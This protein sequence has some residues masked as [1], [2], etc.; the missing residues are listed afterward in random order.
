MK[1]ITM[2]IT[3]VNGNFSQFAK[4][5]HI[6]VTSENT[7]VSADVEPAEFRAFCLALLDVADDIMRKAGPAAEEAQAAIAEAYQVVNNLTDL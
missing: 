3:T 5:V 4:S 7:V 1:G 2:E 6:R